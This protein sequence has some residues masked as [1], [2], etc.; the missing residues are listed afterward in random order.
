MKFMLPLLLILM[1]SACS[2]AEELVEELAEEIVEAVEELVE[3][4]LEEVAEEINA[5]ETVVTVKAFTQLDNSEFA[6]IEF[7]KPFV[8][9]VNSNCD[10]WSREARADNIDATNPHLHFNAASDIFYDGV[11]F[12]WTEYGPEHSQQAID[13]RCAAASNGVSKVIIGDEYMEDHPSVFLHLTSVKEIYS[14]EVYE[15]TEVYETKEGT[16]LIF[17]VRPYTQTDSTQYT[18]I[19]A[20]D[21]LAFTVGASCESWSREAKADNIDATD[22]HLHFNAASDI[23]YNGVN[24]GW[25]EYGPEHSQQG[26]DERCTAGIAGVSKVI[27]VNEFLEDHPGLFLRITSIEELFE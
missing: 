2:D 3:A 27:S 17:T 24:F 8:F 4:V 11:S 23:F 14:D 18:L 6:V 15:S 25:T 21:P 19:E 12:A 13:D 26:I 1:L 16:T 9:T 7:A 20:A 5:K 22:P 10:S